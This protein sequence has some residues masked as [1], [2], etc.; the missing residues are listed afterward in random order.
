MI[1]CLISQIGEI[2]LR[3]GMI[4]QIGNGG[5]ELGNEKSPD[6]SRLIVID[7]KWSAIS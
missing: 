3:L 2:I 5:F 6:N 1:I 4:S 7:R